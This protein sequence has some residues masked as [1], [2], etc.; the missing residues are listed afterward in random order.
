MLR[1]PDERLGVGAVDRRPVPAHVREVPV[2]E[3]IRRERR[4][5]LRVR[6]EVDAET[7]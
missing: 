3:A 4:L 1:P 2:V 7:A 6:A 5:Q